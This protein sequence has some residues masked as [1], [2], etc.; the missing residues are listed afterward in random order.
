MMGLGLWGWKLI[1][2]ACLRRPGFLKKFHGL[3]PKNFVGL[4]LMDF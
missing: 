1:G 3:G 2:L 4:Q